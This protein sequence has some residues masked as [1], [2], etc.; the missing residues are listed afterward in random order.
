[1]IW[2]TQNA[3][4]HEKQVPD[5]RKSIEIVQKLYFEYT[6][7]LQNPTWEPTTLA[8]TLPFEGWIKIN[9]DVVPNGNIMLGVT[10][11]RDHAGSIVFIITKHFEAAS[12]LVGKIRAT[13][14]GIKEALK[15]NFQYC[16]VQGGSKTVIASIF[17]DPNHWKIA[18]SVYQSQKL[19]AQFMVFDCNFISRDFQFVAHNLAQWAIAC[20]CVGIIPRE[21][22][23]PNILCNFAPWST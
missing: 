21:S 13:V 8:W 6:L 4:I 12:S 22:I 15:R 10:I 2:R 14:R 1:H 11:A 7:G 9:F 20:N 16:I 17:K 18:N 23:P 5:V 3:I 19:L